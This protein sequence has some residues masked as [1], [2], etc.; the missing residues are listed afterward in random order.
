MARR[1]SRS[2]ALL[3]L[4]PLAA[5][6]ACG[7][8]GGSGNATAQ[9]VAVTL[10]GAPLLDGTVTQGGATFLGEAL[11]G[12]NGG[13][14]GE[15]ACIDFELT[16]VPTGA[17]VVTATMTLVQR[18]VRGTPYATLGSLLLDHVVY[19]TVLEAGEYARTPIES[20]FAVLSTDATLGP[21]TI[22]VT[23]QVQNDLAR[24]Q[25]QF[26]L[27]FSTENDL[28]AVIDDAEWFCIGSAT[29]LADLPTLVVVYTP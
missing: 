5:L 15:R 24:G 21:R 7:G 13:A 23:A 20:A 9:P 4:V 1:A 6:G 11:V 14:Q 29:T 26:R 22:D 27:R 25:S 3:A 16:G 10:H 19:G 17:H 2:L 18:V 28:D 8:G 12:D